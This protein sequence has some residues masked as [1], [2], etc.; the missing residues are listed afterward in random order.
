MPTAD[1]SPLGS[2]QA[3][4]HPRAGKRILQ[5]QPVETLAS[6]SNGKNYIETVWSRGLRVA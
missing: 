4:Q 3:S 1:L 5:M 6:A 2:Q